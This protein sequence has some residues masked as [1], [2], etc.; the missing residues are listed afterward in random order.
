[1][2]PAHP[3]SPQPTNGSFDLK[4]LGQMIGDG[5]AN[6]PNLPTLDDVCDIYIQQVLALCGGNRLWASEVLRIG[7][8][9]LY[10]YMRK[11]EERVRKNSQ[12]TT[13]E[14]LTGRNEARRKDSLGL[15]FAIF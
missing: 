10:R 15:V 13:P 5:S 11:Y 4:S 6:F 7:R 14:T 9:S 3:Q 12:P 8:T 1:M 2:T